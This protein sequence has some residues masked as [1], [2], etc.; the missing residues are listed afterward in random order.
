M[1][2]LIQGLNRI[3]TLF[4]NL[5]DAGEIGTGTTGE[6][7]TDTDLE[8]PI[9]GSE[10]TDVTTTIN[11][12]FMKKEAR[13]YGVNSS[14]ESVTEVIFKTESPEKAISHITFP[15]VTWND[16]SDIIITTRWYGRGRQK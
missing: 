10:T 12:Q 1:G 13:F 8:T 4:S 3:I 2:M 9:S 5:M 6:T 14:S 16:T 11:D 7:A 15:A